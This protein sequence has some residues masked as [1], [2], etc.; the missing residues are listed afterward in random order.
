MQ[1]KMHH[2]RGNRPKTMQAEPND[3]FPRA[4]G[5]HKKDRNRQTLG[6]P[7]LNLAEPKRIMFSTPLC[8]KCVSVDGSWSTKCLVLCVWET[9]AQLQ[10]SLPGDLTQ[11]RLL[12]TSS[13]RP[14]SRQCRRVS[15]RGN[16]VEVAYL[17]TQPA[18][19][20]KA[21]LDQ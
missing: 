12:F 2:S 7:P 16:V 9:G 14:V 8:A 18:F 20:L 5:L 3:S 6:F 21:E 15:T 4:V 1:P 10:A 19:V 17:R 11:F 13:Q